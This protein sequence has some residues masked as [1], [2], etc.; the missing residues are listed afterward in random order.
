MS[1]KLDRLANQLD[2]NL[3]RTYMVIV[4]ERSITSAALRLNVTQPS[5]SAALRRLE[6]RLDVQLLERGAGRAFRVTAAGETVYREALEMYGGVVRLNELGS[7]DD[8]VLT[9][10]I[11]I[12]RSSHLDFQKVSNVLAEFQYAH[13]A[14]TY[15]LVSTSCG[16]VVRA[17][18]QRVA[19][20]GFCTRLEY[21]PQFTRHKMES[22]EFGFYC[23]P[24]H[25]MY[26]VDKPDPEIIAHSSV[27]GF[28]GETLTGALSQI[29][30]HRVRNEIGET[31][32][33]TTSSIV[34]LIDMIQHLPAIG[35]MAVGHAEK[36]GTPLWR[37]PLS[38]NAL[39]VDM[40]ALVDG[41]R[42]VTPPE[43]ALS[44]YLQSRGLFG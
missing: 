1:F 43:R 19:S 41:D 13:P 18:Q 39:H 28:E 16:D 21:L 2:W 14:V 30:R 33:A 34:D 29:T 23:G 26:Q 20:L 44:M 22:Q 27:V 32:L 15:S 35:C 37:I 4:Q 38:T 11:V 42:Q 8:E 3:L 31:M 7:P 36:L 6:E 40:H 12:Y 24:K 25:P 10:N 9:G 5:V 17:L